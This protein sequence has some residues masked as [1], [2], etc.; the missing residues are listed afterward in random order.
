MLENSINLH[1]FLFIQDDDPS[2]NSKS[3]KAEIAKTGVKQISIPARSADL[4]SIENVFNLVEPR[5]LS[6]RNS[7]YETV[8]QFSECVQVTM[9]DYHDAE[10]DKI[11][12]SISKRKAMVIKDTGRD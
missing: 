8:K 2:Q 11:I 4:N 10:I 3:P 1:S 9:I 5:L 12:K 7:C 6:L